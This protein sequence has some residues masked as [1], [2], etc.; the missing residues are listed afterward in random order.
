MSDPAYTA[1]ALL[2]SMVRGSEKH[3]ETSLEAVTAGF[4]GLDAKDAE[5]ARLTSALER[6][7]SA[8]VDSSR[9]HPAWAQINIAKAALARGESDVEN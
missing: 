9:T 4:R 7:A 8:Y 2:N 3:S 6:I 1:I 5:I